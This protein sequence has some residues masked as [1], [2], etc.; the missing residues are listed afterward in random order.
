MDADGVHI[1]M[2]ILDAQEC[3][4]AL[5]HRFSHSPEDTMDA[6][7]ISEKI[8]ALKLNKSWRNRYKIPPAL[9]ISDPCSNR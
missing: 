4:E 2:S 5:V 8:H 1:V 9:R 6:N 3:Y 7:T